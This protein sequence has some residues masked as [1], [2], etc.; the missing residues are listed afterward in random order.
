MVLATELK[1]CRA[2]GTGLELKTGSREMGT[3]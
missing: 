1:H 2:F 3:G